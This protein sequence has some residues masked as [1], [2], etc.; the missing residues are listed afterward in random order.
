M[1]RVRGRR[2][3]GMGG[4]WIP[5]A[6]RMVGGG[7]GMPGDRLREEGQMVEG[8]MVAVETLEARSMEVQPGEQETQVVSAEH[9]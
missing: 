5:G 4:G 1:S 8:Q 9:W 7:L 2:G 3:L 6:V